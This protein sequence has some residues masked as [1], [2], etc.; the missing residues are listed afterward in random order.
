MYR[1]ISRTQRCLARLTLAMLAVCVWMAGYAEARDRDKLPLF[2]TFFLNFGNGVYILTFRQERTFSLTEPSGLTID[3]S[4]VASSGEVALHSGD[5]N[6]HFSYRFDS[7]LNVLWEP[8]KKDTPNDQSVI[9]RMPPAGRHN[10]ALYVAAQNNTPVV[11]DPGLRER[12]PYERR[13]DRPRGHYETRTEQVLAEPARVQR[14][15]VPDEYEYRHAAWGR[16]EYVLVRPGHHE[17][18]M[19]PARYETR[20]VRVWVEDR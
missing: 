6:R 17:E 18:V 5:G 9:G 16:R 3:G 11:A 4:I 14:R 15:W 20:E 7:N 1:T 12:P 13:W 8:T 19:I 2:N 10:Q